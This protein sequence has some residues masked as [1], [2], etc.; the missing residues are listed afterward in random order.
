MISCLSMLRAL[1]KSMDFHH[2]AFSW[3]SLCF[4]NQCY[5]GSHGQGV[6]MSA[7]IHG[8]LLRGPSDKNAAVHNPHTQLCKQSVLDGCMR[9]KR[10]GLAKG[11]V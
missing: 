8:Q 5:N 2:T 4:S 6:H 10:A 7:G 1:V 3:L 9:Q 11:A